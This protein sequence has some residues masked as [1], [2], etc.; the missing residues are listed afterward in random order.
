MLI[1]T[2]NVHRRAQ[3]LPQTAEQADS[4]TTIDAK[5]DNKRIDCY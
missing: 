1:F 3:F 5:L 4:V 2:R